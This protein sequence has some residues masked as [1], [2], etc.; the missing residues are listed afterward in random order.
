MVYKV[1]LFATNYPFSL[2]EL[3]D[4]VFARYTCIYVDWY[5]CFLATFAEVQVLAKVGAI[6]VGGELEPREI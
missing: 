5:S 1:K 4:K 3:T 2:H 6:V